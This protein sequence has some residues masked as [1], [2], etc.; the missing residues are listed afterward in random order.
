M[1][2]RRSS[3]GKGAARAAALFLACAGAGT[4]SATAAGGLTPTERSFA[5]AI[6]AVRVDNSRPPVAVDGRL[7]RA[8]RSH[9]GELIRTG[10]FRHGNF[11]RRLVG[12]GARGPILGED[13]GWTVAD[14]GATRRIVTWWLTS[15]RHRAVLLRGGFS[16]VGVGVARGTFLG[17]RN[18]IVV[19][20]DFEGR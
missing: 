1:R 10:V 17:H 8:A 4:A 20:A 2:S 9:S 12:F 3:N 6:N 16:R 11:V 19:T 7:V 18:C 13:L 5:A 14:A 15:P